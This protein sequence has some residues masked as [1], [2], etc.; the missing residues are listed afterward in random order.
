MIAETQLE[1]KIRILNLICINPSFGF[2]A[3]GS[4]PPIFFPCLVQLHL[5]SKTCSELDVKQSGAALFV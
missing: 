4:L 1:R 3:G 2:V 5:I